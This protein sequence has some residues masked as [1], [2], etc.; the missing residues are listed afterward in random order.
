MD[1]RERCERRAEV[2]AEVRDG[3]MVEGARV[4]EP[5]EEERERAS[6]G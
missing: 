2:R 1:R 5:D 3:A 6:S 4:V